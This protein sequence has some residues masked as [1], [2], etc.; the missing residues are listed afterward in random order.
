[1]SHTAKWKKIT[2]IAAL[3]SGVLGLN[4]FTPLT[5][6]YWHAL[7]RAIVYL[8]L[9]LSAF[10]FGIRGAVYVAVSVI[11]LF[12]PYVIFHWDG[13]SLE[14]FHQI[15]EALLF[16]GFA[17]TAG[18]LV[19]RE[20]KKTMALLQ[21]ESLAAVGRAVSDVAHDMKA[22]LMAIGGF[23]T[24]VSRALDRE[25]PK[26]KKLQL[27]VQ[28]TA[29]LESM[30]REMLDFGRPMVIRREATD[31]ND[32][33]EEIIQAS[34]PVAEKLRVEVKADLEPSMPPLTMDRQRFKQVLLNL[35]V[36]ALEASP[37]GESVII[38]T[39]QEM[40][41]ANLHVTDRGT[42]I[43]TEDEDKVFQPF[44]SKKKGG[45]G[46]GLPIVKKIVEAHKG[47]IRFHRNADAGMTFTVTLPVA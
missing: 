19:E 22:P 43:D 28:E 16:L 40:G 3:I 2:I 18:I 15:L 13:F 17:L 26:Q 20:K 47:D 21:A 35:T 30:V 23:T 24:Q 44:F 4:Y 37:P 39:T 36:N 1:M 6:G 29:R 42:G 8:P 33:V 14:D 7:Y 11:L 46:L 32:L 9:L 27:V 34:G 38:K 5:T 25:D 45:T 12:I 41:Q 10:W 31:L